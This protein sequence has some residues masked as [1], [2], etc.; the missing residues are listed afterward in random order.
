MH[1]SSQ[2]DNKVFDQPHVLLSISDV[3]DDDL[4]TEG[5]WHLS[6]VSPSGE[7]IVIP[8]LWAEYRVIQETCMQFS[9]EA[10][11]V[12]ALVFNFALRVLS[13]LG[14]QRELLA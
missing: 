14:V 7:I 8:S 6:D 2:E 3:H 4:N 11:P 1:Q 12:V 10:M 13:A 9:V 5:E